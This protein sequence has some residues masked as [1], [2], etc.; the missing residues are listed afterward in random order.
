[1]ISE[2]PYQLV[3]FLTREPS[4]N[5][6]VYGGENGWY[7]QIAIKRRFRV[8]G[9]AEAEMIDRISVFSSNQAPLVIKVKDIYKP[10]SMPVRVLRVAET[11]ELMNF[12]NSFIEFFGAKLES[13][14]PERDGQNYLPHITAEYDGKLVIDADKFSNHTYTVSHA[15]LLKDTDSE[16]SVAYSSFQLGTAT[17]K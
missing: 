15:W 10:E 4:I 2:F 6:H 7:P 13:R 16:D 3:G 12:H 17:I 8:N 1:M 5:E 9:M 14:Y 11:P